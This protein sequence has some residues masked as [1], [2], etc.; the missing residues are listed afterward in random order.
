MQ[1]AEGKAG[2]RA[3][4]FGVFKLKTFRHPVEIVLLALGCTTV[5]FK[6]VV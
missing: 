6:G 3:E 1:K 4:W 2:F 5:Q